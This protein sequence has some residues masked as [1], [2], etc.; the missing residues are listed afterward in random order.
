MEFARDDSPSRPCERRDEHVLNGDGL[1][2]VVEGES[3]KINT[4][5]CITLCTVTTIVLVKYTFSVVLYIS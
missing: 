1:M 3:E 2:R 5:H 4:L